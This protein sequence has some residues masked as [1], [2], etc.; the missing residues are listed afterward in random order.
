MGITELSGEPT[1][2][3]TSH[4]KH[5][6]RKLSKCQRQI[7]SMTKLGVRQAMCSSHSW[8]SFWCH[9]H[10]IF[11]ST[12]SISDE[13]V[14]SDKKRK[15]LL[16]QAKSSSYAIAC[17][18]KALRLSEK[19]PWKQTRRKVAGC[20]IL[21]G[22]CL[23]A[24]VI[25]QVSQFDYELANFDP[26]EILGV[27]YNTPAKEIKKKYREM[28]LI[29]HPDKP[30]GNEK[31]F[32][33]LTKAYDALTDE[34]AKY[35][36]EHYGNPDG[37]QAMVFGIG[38]P[39]WIVEEKNAIYVLGLYTLVFMVG[40]PS[41]VYYWWSNS[42]KFSGEQ[43]LLDTTQLY[44]YFFHK[45]PHMMLRRV[46]M[47]LAA[48]LE[49]E[50][51]HN[52]EVA[53]RP[54][55]N[56]EIPHLMKSLSNLGVNNKEKPLCFSYS[57]KARALLHAHMSRISLPEKTLHED[58]LYII[59]KCPFLIQEMVTCT[60]QLILLA[61]AG[62]I[63]RLPSLD[64]IE[65]VMKLSPLVVQALWDKASPLLQLPHIEE[66]MLKH[67]HT[68]R[69]NI[70]SLQQVAKLEDD[71]RRSL[72]RKLTDE[73]YKDV[74][75]VLASFPILDVIITTEVVDDEE[76]H[77]VTAG[78]IVTVTLLLERR[79]M[80]SLMNL[81][82][83]DNED[84]NEDNDDSDS[85]MVEVTHED[86]EAAK[87]ELS[88]HGV[89]KEDE[90]DKEKKP[91]WRKPQKKK[92]GKKGGGGQKQKTKNKK[93]DT[94]TDDA[95]AATSGDTAQGSNSTMIKASDD[96]SSIQNSNTVR[97]KGK[98]S[99]GRKGQQQQQQEGSSDEAESSGSEDDSET[100]QLNKAQS[101][102]DSKVDEEDD[103]AEWERF[104]KKLNK[105]EKALEG[106][107]KVSH[108]VH[109]PYFT[110]DKQ[111]F[112]W[113]YISDRKN[114]ALVTPPIHVTGL[115]EREEVELKFTAPAK[116]GHYSFTVAV[117]S[118]SYLGADV[119]QDIKL[120]VHEA[121]DVPDE[122]P[123]WEFEDEDE[124]ENSKAEESDDEFAT[125]DDFDDDDDDDE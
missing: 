55:D 80:D 67:F 4:L 28:S 105:R 96:A 26:Y 32:M 2:S 123:Q 27:S 65:F 64:T 81:A 104:Q 117:R 112:W 7:F 93:K 25:Y 10:G 12:S 82:M 15:H 98:A 48:S 110:D 22:W 35:N 97:H 72:L 47:V 40:L 49:F 5:E 79:T 70:R 91:L 125:D 111:E 43:V 31:L 120:D 102:E 76:Q 103:E 33:K 109:S 78:A 3:T 119:S 69:R 30:T 73:E 62:R 84:G 101:N 24:Y 66:D 50:R 114:H 113:C 95:S 121:R 42:I 44:Y 58:R 9:R 54:T 19:N 107:S 14:D 99:S 77:V 106:K 88:A 6:L 75:R 41:A 63:G 116:P 23:M 100:D 56:Q 87:D 71:E 21:V 118:D 11:L 68:K 39:S 92:G 18:Q 38:L 74:I 20:L 16:S 86:N 17:E 29:Y 1:V 94:K 108:S 13:N 45:T 122:H 52:S 8:V 37:P 51:G 36:W 61:H 83:S 90:A 115:V 124:D 89:N 46:L 59:K 57:V 60:S 85:D 34:T 53:E